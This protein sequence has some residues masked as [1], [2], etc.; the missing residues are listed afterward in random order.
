MAFLS[1]DGQNLRCS[2]DRQLTEA[3]GKRAYQSILSLVSENSIKV[4]GNAVVG[5]LFIQALSI[6]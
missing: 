2:A 6:F 3:P 4:S 5:L 1:L